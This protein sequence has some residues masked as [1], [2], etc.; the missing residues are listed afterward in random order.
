MK[1]IGII[2]YPFPVLSVETVYLGLLGKIKGGFLENSAGPT[3]NTMQL[4]V[5]QSNFET[6]NH[7]KLDYRSDLI[8]SFTGDSAI[9]ILM[10][11]QYHRRL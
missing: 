2:L 10:K 7:K 4:G 11:R 6:L 8:K 9:R 5:N 3:R 1:V